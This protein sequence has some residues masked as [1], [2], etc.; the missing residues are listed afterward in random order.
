[1]FKATGQFRAAVFFALILCVVSMPS[2]AAGIATVA[3]DHTGS[4]PVGQSL[5]AAVR[6]AIRG[7]E[8]FTLG[9]TGKAP[10][11]ISLV[12]IDPESGTD[13]AGSW[14]VAA[15]VFLAREARGAEDSGGRPGYPLFRTGVVYRVGE[16]KIDE[17]ARRKPCACLRLSPR[18]WAS[19]CRPRA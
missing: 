6:D 19:P 5:K 16:Y 9:E 10:F 8:K 14:T 18:R 17:A 1:M 4:D 3:V 13:N 7:S 12:T 15:I 2:W 11:E